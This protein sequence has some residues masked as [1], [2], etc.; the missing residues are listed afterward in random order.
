MILAAG[1][2]ERMRPLTDRVPKAMLSVGGKPLIFWHLE[3]LASAGFKRV[4]VNHAHLGDQIEA[5]V[6]NGS[7][8]Q[9]SVLYSREPEAL[10]TAGGLRNAQALLDCEVFAVVNADVFSDYPYTRLREALS[11]LTPD[12]NQVHL[13]MVDNPAHHPRGDFGIKD[14]RAVLDSAPLLTFG[15]LSAFRTQVFKQV[16]LGQKQALAPLLR[17]L[18]GQ[19]RVGAEHYRG[20]WIDVGTPQR[21]AELDTLLLRSGTK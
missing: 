10:E 5:A 6:G 12:G 3:K 17:E 14:G 1:R 15:G 7:R 9:L 19:G 11:R 4:V 20:L 2:G 18:I 8:W 21:L 13:V 16:P